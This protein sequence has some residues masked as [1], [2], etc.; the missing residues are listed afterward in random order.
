M[1]ITVLSDMTPAFAR[2]GIADIVIGFV[3][4]DAAL[5]IALGAIAACVGFFILYEKVTG[6][7]FVKSKRKRREARN[8]RKFV[9]WEYRREGST[10][11]G[12]I[13]HAAD[14]SNR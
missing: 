14:G 4:G 8:R 6:K 13:P 1:A 7:S 9:L 10:S 11:S 5:W 2:T 12:E 3:N